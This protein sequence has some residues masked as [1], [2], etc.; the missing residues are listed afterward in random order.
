MHTAGKTERKSILK[1]L[2]IYFTTIEI[3]TRYLWHS[4]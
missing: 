1:I 4:R 2:V 3:G